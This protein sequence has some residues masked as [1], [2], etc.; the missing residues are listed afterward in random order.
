MR[1]CVRAP[2]RACVCGYMDTG[3]PKCASRLLVPL[4]LNLGSSLSFYL[5]RERGW[6]ADIEDGRKTES[7]EGGQRG[8]K[9]R[10][11]TRTRKLFFP[12]IVV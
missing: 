5:A 3:N 9:N 10:T 11:R 12:R 1:A 6:K 4:F 7:V 2:V 8:W